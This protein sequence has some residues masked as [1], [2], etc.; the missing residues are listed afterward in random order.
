[1]QFA[2]KTVNFA[3]A[4]GQRARGLVTALNSRIG[5]FVNGAMQKASAVVSQ[6]RGLTG[7]AI[8]Q[9]MGMAKQAFN[10]VQSRVS[11]GVNLVKAAAQRTKDVAK[12]FIPFY[13]LIAGKCLNDP[14]DAVTNQSGR[15]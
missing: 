3:K 6:G 9:F 14:P 15:Q 8:A 1:M 13:L 2:Q 5:G 11:Q 10:A 7:K 12:P 4:A